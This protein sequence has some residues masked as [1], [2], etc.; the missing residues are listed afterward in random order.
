MKI[1]K[2]LIRCKLCF[3]FDKKKFKK[4]ILW[5]F[6]TRTKYSFHKQLN[7]SVTPP[8]ITPLNSD[9]NYHLNIKVN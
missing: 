1:N 6:Q 3:E 9:L 7:F 2:C 4:S 8:T 5:R